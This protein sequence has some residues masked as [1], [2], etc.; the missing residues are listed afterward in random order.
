MTKKK[1]SVAVLFLVMCVMFLFVACNNEEKKSA[2]YDVTLSSSSI[3]LDRYDTATLTAVVTENEVETDFEVTW[4]SDNTNVVAVDGGVLTA[5]GVGTA[6]VTATYKS[7]KAEC[8]V[9]V[10]DT[11]M[12]PILVLSED[13]VEIVIGGSALK[14]DAYVSYKNQTVSD[15]E[16]SYKIGDTAIAEVDVT[17]KVTAKSYGT[18]DLT[19]SAK[20]HDADPTYLTQTIP[21]FVKENVLFEVESTKNEV[22]I[23]N[24][25][26]DG[27]DFWNTAQMKWN[28]ASKISIRPTGWLSL[29]TFWLPAGRWRRGSLC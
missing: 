19:V 5:K 9:T 24:G 22:Y 23:Y 7:A 21:V 3:T 20:W 12:R 11:G 29:M 6:K 16:I 27:V 2:N 8:A 4:A 26:V 13:E 15:A 10:E 17:G 25:T 28:A 1:F 14:V 18:T